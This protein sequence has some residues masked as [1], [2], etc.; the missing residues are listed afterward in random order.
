MT[1]D[2][3]FYR[4]ALAERNAAWHEIDRLRARVAQLEADAARYRWMRDGDF[5]AD[6][7][8]SLH[9]GL[10]GNLLMDEELDAA[11]DA[12]RGEK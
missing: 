5:T 3:S 10:D 6:V 1:I 12:A 11:I 8:R 7:E 4:V 2:E 9:E